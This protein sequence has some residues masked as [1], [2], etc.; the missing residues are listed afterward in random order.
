[1]A[2]NSGLRPK[3][4]HEFVSKQAGGIEILGYT[5]KDGKNYL[6]TKR[7]QS[8]RY[9]EVSALL[10]Y[11][12]HQS[13][14][15]SFFYDFQMD[16]E[17]Q[18]TNIFWADAQMINDYEYFGDVVTFD[19]TYKTNKDYRPLGVF[20][21]NNHRQ[22]VIFGATLLYDETIPS[23]QWLF[24]TFLKAMGGENPKT[25]LTDQDVAMGQ[26]ISLVMPNTFHGLCTWHIRQ[27]ALRHMNHL[28]QNGST[29]CL[30]FEACID[31]H[32]EESEFLNA[33]QELIENH[34]VPA[35][36]WLHTIFKVKEKWAWAYVRKT[37][38]VGMRTTQLSQS[39]NAALKNHLKSDLHL[40][41]FF[42]HFERVVNGK[43]NNESEAEYESVN[44]FP[45]LKMVKA[46]MLVQT[47]KIYTPRIFEEFQEEYE[48][49]QGTCIKELK[50][51]LYI[52]TS[53][54]NSHEKRVMGNLVDQ[55]VACDCRKFETH[56]I[57]CSHALKVLDVM[58]IKIIPQHYILK[59]W[60]REARVG[61]NQDWK[62][63]HIEL[64]IKANFM[65]RYNDLYPRVLNTTKR[66]CVSHVTYTFWSKVQKESHKII[67]EMLAKNSMDEESIANCHVS[68]SIANSE[69]QN[70]MNAIVNDPVGPKGIMKRECLHK[71]RKR[72][73]F[74]VEKWL[75]REREINYSN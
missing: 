65:N 37:F 73:Q 23:F 19:T 9:G 5:K 58:N 33:W 75:E 64:D 57:L 62:P 60:T 63:Q 45:R 48:E 55:K 49:Y 71:G 61:M 46:P 68:I 47:S 16:V 53:Y 40:V 20:G 56:G 69:I 4:F 26:A 8:L 34:K 50:Q 35:D 24:Q 38:T 32:E 41:H 10:M 66:L 21:L 18:L 7:M 13:E 12:K 14:N 28:Y 27:N 36:S 29:F 1:M 72:P 42:T 74:W 11:F 22:T 6:R 43:R 30:E 59:R 44:K 67:E 70:N 2:D 3:D 17:D 25:I 39:F 15:L 52:V 31:L 51:G 54:D